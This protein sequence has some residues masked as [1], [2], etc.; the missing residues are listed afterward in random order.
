M[1][2]RALTVHVY[3]AIC[4]LVEVP[5]RRAWKYILCHFDYLVEINRSNDENL[6][7]WNVNRR[8][9]VCICSIIPQT[10]NRES[11]YSCIASIG[12]LICV[13]YFPRHRSTLSNRRYS[14]IDRAFVYSVVASLE[15]D[16]TPDVL[17]LNHVILRGKKCG[18]KERLEKDVKVV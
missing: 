10:V 12:S 17:T 3:S 9:R 11:R 14:C 4:R 15:A 8:R 6:F 13:T 5:Q 7:L 2:S 16:A 18:F 1:V